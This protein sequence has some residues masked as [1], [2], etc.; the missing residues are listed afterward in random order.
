MPLRMRLAQWSA[1]DVTEKTR[2][3]FSLPFDYIQEIQV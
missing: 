1:F 2:N 3:Q